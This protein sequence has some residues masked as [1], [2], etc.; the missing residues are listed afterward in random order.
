MATLNPM[1]LLRLARILA[2]TALFL[3]LMARVRFPTRLAGKLNGASLQP[4]G[5][6]LAAILFMLIIPAK[7]VGGAFSPLFILVGA[8]G[9]LYAA[10]K[11]DFGTATTA[12]LAALVSSHALAR[13]H[14]AQADFERSLSK[15][16]SWSSFSRP[17]GASLPC[18]AG[19]K[20]SPGKARCQRDFIFGASSVTGKMLR[21]N[22]WQPPVGV[23]PSGLALLYF[24]ASAWQALDYG[25]TMQPLLRH[26]AEQGHVVM[27]VG[28]TLAPEADLN[29]M[30]GD[31]RL[32]V[33][34]MKAHAGDLGAN[35]QRV[36]L[37]GA[38][39]GGHL[40]LLAAYSSNLSVAGVVAC[41]APTDMTRHFAEYGQMEPR[42]PPSSE[43]ITGEM[44]PRIH[45][46]S[47]L[48]RLLTRWR[49]WPAYR[50]QNMPG[51]ALLLVNLLGG[52]PGELPVA[53]HMASPL[54]HARRDCPP[55]LQIYGAHDFYFPAEHGRR[56]HHALLDCGA[57][58]VYL[59]LP[60]AEHGFDSFA[61]RIS[62]SAQAAVEAIEHFLAVMVY[63]AGSKSI[64][65]EPVTPKSAAQRVKSADKLTA[66]PYRSLL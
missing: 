2:F 23:S 13:L 63:S 16:R 54:Y 61:W 9:A 41:Y 53:Y 38:S 43:Q 62:P 10:H 65:C 64:P 21:C 60:Y 51:G 4:L 44:R 29:G 47:L 42:Q 57:T 46:A 34:W 25:L 45:D 37:M 22:I 8:I 1:K 40:A 20:T 14:A 15:V 48:D 26:L 39:G 11:A 52:T 12:A 19:R 18:L 31:V 33:E 66:N 27:D 56:L 50:Y 35:P 36:V 28:Y 7:L 59:E 58:S 55:T 3:S 5:K 17:A 32:A 49:I 30:L 24:H 6:L